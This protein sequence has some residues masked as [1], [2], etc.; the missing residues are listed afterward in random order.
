MTSRPMSFQRYLTKNPV[1]TQNPAKIY[2]LRNCKAPANKRR[3]LARTPGFVNYGFSL[4]D[5]R[6]CFAHFATV[7]LDTIFKHRSQ[8]LDY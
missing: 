2:D 8:V 4:P 5:A 3:E 1:Y 7:R 6:T